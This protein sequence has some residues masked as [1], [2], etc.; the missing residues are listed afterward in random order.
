MRAWTS[1]AGSCW[2]AHSAW[3][4]LSTSADP[5]CCRHPIPVKPC[6]RL[7][8]LALRLPSGVRGPLL[9]CAFDRF[10]WILRCEVIGIFFRGC[11]RRRGYLLWFVVVDLFE[12]GFG[13]AG[14]VVGDK[15]VVLNYFEQIVAPNRSGIAPFVEPIQNSW[16]INGCA[17]MRRL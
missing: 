16:A 4:K 3:A 5:A 1:K 15:A 6:L 10:V 2:S 8:P 9:F 17:K 7:F 13:D 14:T 12:F 11:N